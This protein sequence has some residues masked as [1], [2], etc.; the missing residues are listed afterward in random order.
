MAVRPEDALSGF[1]TKPRPVASSKLA[2]PRPVAS[3]KLAT[4]IV[5]NGRSLRAVLPPS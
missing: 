4:L 5:R 2:K 3:S 1:D